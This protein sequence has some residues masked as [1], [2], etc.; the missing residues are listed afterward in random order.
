[1]R[2]N[3][4]AA[5]VRIVTRLRGRCAALKLSLPRKDERLQKLNEFRSLVYDADL[6]PHIIRRACIHI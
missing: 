1:M 2:L 4:F 5:C 3:T 6:S